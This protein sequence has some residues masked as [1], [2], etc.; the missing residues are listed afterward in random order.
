MNPA[1]EENAMD[2]VNNE[3]FAETITNHPRA[4]FTDVPSSNGKS[5]SSLFSMLRR[6]SSISSTDSSS[7]SQSQSQNQT[8]LPSPNP[9]RPNS[10][11]SSFNIPVRN[12]GTSIQQI[13]QMILPR[14][15]EYTSLLH[16]NED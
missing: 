6:Q 11:S 14:R 9:S 10:R 13:Q 16:T 7:H 8:P 1:I 12:A 15:S 3:V 2:M 4:S 5:N